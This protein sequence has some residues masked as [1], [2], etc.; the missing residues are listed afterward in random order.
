[1]YIFVTFT[2]KDLVFSQY[3]SPLGKCYG[4]IVRCAGNMYLY[5][6]RERARRET[7]LMRGC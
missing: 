4:E 5:E 7:T 1:M 6:E 2:F 3:P